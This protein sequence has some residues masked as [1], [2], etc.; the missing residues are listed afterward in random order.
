[1]ARKECYCVRMQLQVCTHTYIFKRYDAFMNDPLCKL[2]IT[3]CVRLLC[4]Q[5]QEST[6]SQRILALE[7]QLI[8]VQASTEQKI[9]ADEARVNIGT[10]PCQIMIHTRLSHALH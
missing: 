3:Y 10:V 7:Q 1:M 5:Q 8:T 9:Q 4:S 6:L 2:Y